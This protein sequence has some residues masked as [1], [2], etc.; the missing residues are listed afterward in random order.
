MAATKPKP[1]DDPELRIPASVRAAAEAVEQFYKPLEV[2]PAPEVISEPEPPKPEDPPLTSEVTPPTE[3]VEPAPPPPPDWEA[4][5]KAMKGRWEKADR[6][7][8]S[9]LARIADLEAAPPARTPD[10]RERLISPEEEN[11]YG[12]ELLDVVGRKAKEEVLPEVTELRKY[13]KT[14]EQRLENVDTTVR[15]TG[16][17]GFYSALDGAV[18]EWRNLNEDERFLDWLQLPDPYSGVIRQELLNSAVER[19]DAPR[20]ARFFKGFLAEEAALVPQIPSPPPTP[21]PAV[22]LKDLAAP[23]RAKTAATTTPLPAEKPIYTSAQISKF[24]ADVAAGRY[25]GRDAEKERLE[26]DIFE[27]TREGRIR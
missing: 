16:K 1:V 19:L 12:R 6:D 11:D 2:E 3:P 22:D 26:R 25:R 21:R 17:S 14:L 4:R 27:A 18:A 15:Q 10:P 20:A 13:I 24:Y 7:L 23:G 8:A 5:Y 9:A